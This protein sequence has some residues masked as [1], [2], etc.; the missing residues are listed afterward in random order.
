MDG[1]AAR[2][3]THITTEKEIKE[4]ESYAK[5]M[6]KLASKQDVHA[7][8]ET[9]IK[10]H[11]FIENL[12]QNEQLIQISKNITL[13]SIRYRISSLRIPGR[14]QKSIKEHWNIVEAIKVR[15][16]KKAERMGQKHIENAL[17][18]ILNNVVGKKIQI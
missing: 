16:P 11:R 6:E 12:C 7:Y 5:K 17:K 1:L 3:A 10:F 14:F 18:N 15:D 4:L 2:L 9:D 13:Q 8:S